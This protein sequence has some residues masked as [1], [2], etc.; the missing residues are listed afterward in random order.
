M[1]RAEYL[2]GADDDDDDGDGRNILAKR[3]KGSPK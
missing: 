1:K 2:Q 3:R